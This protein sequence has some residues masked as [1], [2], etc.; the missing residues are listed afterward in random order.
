VQAGPLKCTNPQQ[1]KSILEKTA[2]NLLGARYSYGDTGKRGFDC[3]GFVLT[4]CK[5]IMGD[6]V[7]LPRS[8]QDMFSSIKQNVSLDKAQKGDLLFFKT[9]NGISHVA[10]YWGKDG[11][12]NDLMCHA[13]SSKGVEVRA[14][15]KDSYWSPRFAGI[16][17]VNPLFQVLYGNSFMKLAEM[18]KAEKQ[19]TNKIVD[20]SDSAQLVLGE[21]ESKL[22]I[23]PIY[24]FNIDKVI[25]EVDQISEEFSSEHRIEMKSHQ[26]DI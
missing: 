6:N 12:G 8:S 4:L 16:K 9:G 24:D 19:N 20:D 13:S 2:Q 1:C 25:Q 21:T 26:I 10:M 7:A 15:K 23:P 11:Q 14:F 17:R 22:S 3:S 18:D 5:S